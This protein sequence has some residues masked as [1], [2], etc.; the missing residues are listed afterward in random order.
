MSESDFREDLSL[1]DTFVPANKIVRLYAMHIQLG[2][3]SAR[4]ESD[5]K[6]SDL[7]LKATIIFIR[8]QRISE[9][10]R[11]QMADK[12]FPTAD[13]FLIVSFTYVSSCLW[14]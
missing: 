10:G 12:S 2:L 11:G 13:K 4:T 6:A 7:R 8:K 9:T 1:V 5:P 14:I 3:H